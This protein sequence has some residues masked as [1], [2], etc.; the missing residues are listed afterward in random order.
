V[1][2]LFWS[3]EI[4]K[5]KNDQ[6]HF[7]RKIDIVIPALSGLFLGANFISQQPEI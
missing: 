5:L 3:L 4:T 1:V 2:V 7:D 6:D